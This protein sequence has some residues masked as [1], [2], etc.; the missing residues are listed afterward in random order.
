MRA[1]V[2]WIR[3]PQT[4]RGTAVW[5]SEEHALLVK[6]PQLAAPEHRLVGLVALVDVEYH[7]HTA[8][9]GGDHRLIYRELVVIDLVVSGADDRQ[10][11]QCLGLRDVG[12]RVRAPL[13][14][15][16]ILCGRG[17]IVDVGL[18]HGC[19]TKVAVKCPVCVELGDRAAPMTAELEGSVTWVP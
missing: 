15:I 12:V 11:G 6:Q 10:V 19:D 4:L 7:M 5:S 13:A 8:T 14:E 9:A 3:V 2:F 18:L 16:Q 17:R 1:G